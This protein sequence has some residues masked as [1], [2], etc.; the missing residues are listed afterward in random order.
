MARTPSSAGGFYSPPLN[1]GQTVNRGES[2]PSTSFDSFF[3]TTALCMECLGVFCVTYIF[4]GRCPYCGNP[5]A[6]DNLITSP[7]GRDDSVRLALATAEKEK[8][9]RKYHVI[10]DEEIYRDDY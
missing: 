9:K 7:Y 8:E 10:T 6:A 1:T 3:S 5:G 4:D 2:T